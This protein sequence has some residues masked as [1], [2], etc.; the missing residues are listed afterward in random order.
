MYNV[1]VY[2]KSVE[3]KSD[4]LRGVVYVSW[5]GKEISAVY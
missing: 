2:D 5:D 3:S 4:A 1:K